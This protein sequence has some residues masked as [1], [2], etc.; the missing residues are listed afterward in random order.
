MSQDTHTSNPIGLV[1][2]MVILLG[3]IIAPI[4]VIYTVTKSPEAPAPKPAAV[5]RAEVVKNIAPLAQVEMA[6]ASDASNVEKSGEEVVNLACA[7]CHASGMMGAPKL[8]DAGAWSARIAQGYETL[9][10]HAI[11][12]IRSMPARGGNS[13]L[14][15][16]EMAKAVAY[17]AN[18]AG[19]D[20][21]A[22][23]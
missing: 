6:S 16:S 5:D 18:Q 12:G 1:E 7:A 15:D 19:A 21:K 10:K 9:T 2:K 23:D 13:S 14:T 17:M 3:G 4:F 11:E 22:P 8:G 20:F